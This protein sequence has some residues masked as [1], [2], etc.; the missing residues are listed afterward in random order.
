MG[1]LAVIFGFILIISIFA[2]GVGSGIHK[3]HLAYKERKEV[4]DRENRATNPPASARKIEQLEQRVRVLERIATENRSDL[5]AQ[6][7]QLRDL[8][9]IGDQVAFK[10]TSA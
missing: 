2:L 8:D 7:E 10:E 4:L 1:E 9:A 3:R 5:A 6:I